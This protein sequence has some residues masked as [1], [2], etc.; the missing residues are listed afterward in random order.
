MTSDARRVLALALILTCIA[1]APGVAGAAAEDAPPAPGT[2]SDVYD[3][4]ENYNRWMFSFNMAIDRSVLRPVASGYRNAVP[5][6]AR[7]GVSNFLDNLESPLSMFSN[8]LQGNPGRAGSDLARFTLNLTLGLG[9]VLDPAS[10]LGL[11]QGD[12]DLGQALG[13]WGV[14]AG[15]YLVLPFMP[16]RSLRDWTG[17]LGDSLFEPSHYVE[18]DLE[19]VTLQALDLTE[20]R[21]RLLDLDDALNA[22]YDQYA[23]VRDATLQRREYKVRD[24]VTAP[25]DYDEFYEDPLDEGLDEPVAAPPPAQELPSEPPSEPPPR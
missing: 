10:S 24:G 12:E 9:G 3:P 5:A 22:A 19:R 2:R 14:G 15:P 25:I 8:L 13:K 17:E 21:Y 1:A 6:P 16:A 18:D 23:F 20:E 11:K 7:T 4:W